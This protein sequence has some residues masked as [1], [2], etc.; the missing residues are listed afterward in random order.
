MHT[1]L[2]SIVVPIYGVEKYLEKCIQ[3]IIAQTYTNLEI[4]L[5]DDGSVDEC[6]RIC[7]KYSQIDSRIKV[8]HKKNGGLVSA[9]KAGIE[10]CMGKYAV[11]V[12]GDD[13]LEPQYIN[14]MMDK[15]NEY[16]TDI[17]ICSH[18][19]EGDIPEINGIFFEEGYYDRESLEQIIFPKML[20][21]GEFYKFGIE[22]N[23]FLKL[24]H[25]EM[26]RKYQQEVPNSISLGE[27]T[28]CFY[29]L[30]LECQSCYIMKEPLYHYRLNTS[31]MT[32][33]YNRNQLEGTISLI[34]YLKN[35]LPTELYDLDFQLNYYHCFITLLNIVNIGRG[36][37]GKR[38][39]DHYKEFMG[40]VEQTNFDKSIKNCAVNQKGIVLSQKIGLILLKSHLYMMVLVLY[41]IEYYI[42]KWRNNND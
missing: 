13:W 10:V 4:V 9:R 21:R 16:N 37:K 23:V 31:G 11:Y 15:Q 14:E 17:V 41:Y 6:P 39:I 32:L 30:F 42:K 1:E 26:L 22:P 35:W 24:Y 18:V 36:F 19:R 3:S 33:K 34:N 20:Y 29:P 8:I 12:D 2:V 40:Y 5:V 38:I 25:T 7:D 27:D 28:A